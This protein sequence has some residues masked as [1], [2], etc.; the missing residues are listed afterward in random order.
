MQRNILF[1]TT[2]QQRYD[3]LGCNGGRFAAT[4]VIDALASQGVRYERAYAQNTV[5]G[6]ARSSFHTGQMPS[7][8]GVIANGVPLPRDAPSVARILQEAGYHTSLIGKVHFEPIADPT[9]KYP[10]NRLA[11]ENRTGP[12]RGYDHVMMSGH[13]PQ[14][15]SHYSN[16]IRQ[17]HPDEAAEFLSIFSTRPGGDTG[18]PGVKR[19]PVDS[20]HYH[21][22]WTADRAIEWL[23]ELPG[24]APWFCWLSFPDPHHPWDPP[25]E[26]WARF[27]WR[28]LP[29][30]AGHPGSEDAIRRILAGRPEHWLAWFDG[31]VPNI[32]AA[33]GDYVPRDTDIDQLREINALVHVKN[34]MLDEACGRVLA[35][36][37]DKGWWD[38]T[39]IFFTTDHGEFQ[40]ELGLLF[41]GPYHVDALLRL[42][43]VWRPAPAAEVSP[44]VITDPVGQIDLAPTFCEI[45]G[46]TPPVWMQG[47][48]LPVST[49]DRR[50]RVLAEWDS[51]LDTGYRLRTIVRDGWLCTAYEPTDL[52]YGLP[53][54]LRYADFRMAPPKDRI[55][56]TGTEGE[57]FNLNDDPHQWENRWNDPTLRGLRNELVADLYDHLPPPRTPRLRPEAMA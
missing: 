35:T 18:A 20:A 7:T 15:A 12:Y 6:P 42:P 10:Q 47:R 1:I 48:P 36:V 14:G 41:K 26:E 23:T 3:A 43:L 51:Q 55:I 45:A 40:G 38:N 39:D 19:N 24:D 25:E 33:P 8:H 54:E 37:A 57:L 21:T 2:D 50:E 34:E 17:H 27:D 16:W 4:P 31:R 28:R 22:A 29:L 46:I 44:T 30:P 53:M 9:G 13:G 49:A 32:D 11:I 5:C 52:E 56:Y